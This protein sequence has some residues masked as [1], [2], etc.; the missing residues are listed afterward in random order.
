MKTKQ[1]F[2]NAASKALALAATVMMMSMAF[3]A[4]SS[5]NDDPKPDP[6]PELKA[7]TVTFD[8][9]EKPVLSAEYR[10]EGGGN[11]YLYLNLNADG[12]EY[13][14]LAVN[15]SLHITG[16]PVKLTQKQ[17]YSWSWEVSYMTSEGK[18]PFYASGKLTETELPVFTTGTLTVSG[19]PIGTINIKLVNGRVKGTDGKEHTFTASYSGTMKE[20]QF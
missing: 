20:F 6:E 14:I 8:G 13:I 9:V 17:N 7:N 2:A 1:F 15:Q 3:S 19:S 18:H 12:S 11:Y 5:D 4:C 16:T 10:N